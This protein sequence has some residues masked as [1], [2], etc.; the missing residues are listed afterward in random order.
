MVW[1]RDGTMSIACHKDWCIA[2]QSK[3]NGFTK[4]WPNVYSFSI[5]WSQWFDQG[6]AQCLLHFIRLGALL[7]NSSPMVFAKGWPNVYSLSIGLFLLWTH[8]SFMHLP[9]HKVLKGFLFW[10][11]DSL[12]AND[13]R[14]LQLMK[15]SCGHPCWGKCF[16]IQKKKCLGVSYNY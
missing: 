6:M 9:Q 5:G 3:P 8:P 15:S 16:Q 12:H 7:N 2:K 14:S 10:M 11:L 4:G 1:S 13:I